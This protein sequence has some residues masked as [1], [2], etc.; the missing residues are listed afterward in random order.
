MKS[1]S[2]GFPRSQ[3]VLS[4]IQD[5]FWQKKS[6]IQRQWWIQVPSWLFL[7]ASFP[8]DLPMLLGLYPPKET[9]PLRDLGLETHRQ[10]KL[11]PQKLPSTGNSSLL[12]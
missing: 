7:Q 10:A 9:A 5:R 4:G 6:K 3:G 1:A 12:S 2:L 8:E 11:L